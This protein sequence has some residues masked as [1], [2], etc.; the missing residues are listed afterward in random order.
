MTE[1]R[2]EELL[3]LWEHETNEDWT[4][5][6]RDELTPEEAALVDSWDSDFDNEIARMIRDTY[7]SK[8]ASQFLTGPGTKED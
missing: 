4:Q 2:R 6:W 5:E 3:Y 8:E 7:K 1:E